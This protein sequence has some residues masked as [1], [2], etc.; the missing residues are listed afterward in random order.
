MISYCHRDREFLD[1]LRIH[2]K[3]LE[4]EFK[5]DIWDDT[6]IRGGS[7]WGADIRAA[8]QS[9][10]VAILLISADFLG[11]D[12]IMEHEL[13]ALLE[14]KAIVDKAILPIIVR[15]CS[16]EATEGLSSLQA[17]NSS[18]ETLADMAEP[19]LERS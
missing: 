15:P 11:S 16:Y 10:K 1:R 6:R 8:I 5:I 9:A 7:E 18:E 17:L 14:S 3:P 19:T 2:L 12:F 13:P 4:K